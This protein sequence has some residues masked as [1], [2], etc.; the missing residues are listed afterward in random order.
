MSERTSVE[1]QPARESLESIV[2][3]PVKL[4]KFQKQMREA[5]ELRQVQEAEARRRQGMDICFESEERCQCGG[6]ILFRSTK[7]FI[8]TGETMFGGPTRGYVRE[9]KR[10]TCKDCGLDYDHT[11]GRFHQARTTLAEMRSPPGDDWKLPKKTVAKK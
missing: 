11:H 4:R 1:S 5:N 6:A 7:K 10:A 3:D 8:Q 2:A 9:T